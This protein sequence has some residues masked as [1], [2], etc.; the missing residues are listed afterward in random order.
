MTGEYAIITLHLLP[1]GIFAECEDTDESVLIP[2]G[3]ANP[4]IDFINRVDSITNP[5]AT[6]TLTDKGKQEIKNIKG[7]KQ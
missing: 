2:E 3:K 1:G 6:F 4:L 7:E 5:N